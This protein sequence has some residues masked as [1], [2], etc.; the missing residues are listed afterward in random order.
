MPAVS[1]DG[2]I[3]VLLLGYGLS[4]SVLVARRLLGAVR[5]RR[6]LSVAVPADDH[7]LAVATVARLS[8]RMG[9]RTPRVLLLGDCPGGAFTIG[10]RRVFV[11][12]DPALL[13]QLDERELEG[14]LAHELA[15]VARRDGLVQTLVGVCRDLTFFLPAV[16]LAAR[17]LRREQ[18]ESADE[19]AS[20]VTRRPAALA[21][22]ILK[23]WERSRGLPGA[24]LSC[25][26]VPL[27]P[28]RLALAGI[29]SPARPQLSQAA[30]TV[31]AR[32]ER[33]LDARP[34]VTAM[35][36]VAELA[37]AMAVLGAA[38]G[39]ALVV[40]RWIAT[41]LN[42]YS[43]SFIYLAEPAEQTV[44]SP[45]FATFRW[46]AP[47]AVGPTDSVEA[48]VAATWPA[49]P[50]LAGG[51]SPATGCPC[52]E[53]QAQLALGVSASAPPVGQRMLWRSDGRDPWELNEAPGQ[54]RPL[55]TLG[56]ARPRMGFF[57]ISPSS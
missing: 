52:V 1:V 41:D 4:A 18:E 14:L 35:R 12:V 17:W 49:W 6:L 8:R 28:R 5:A 23:V 55:W 22:S 46:L 27:A 51:A 57:L 13:E 32:V 42:T 2:G 33:L 21:S 25:T 45:A 53:S 9:L 29:G 56:D 10:L 31:A 16:H 48:E 30:Q 37:L 43:L 19:V 39:A 34:A 3:D 36:R 11:A 7:C 15:H 40:P 38:S 24:R 26:A 20:T 50:V 47:V 54:A 44:E